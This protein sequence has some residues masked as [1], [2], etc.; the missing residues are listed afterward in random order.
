MQAAANADDAHEN[1]CSDEALE[2]GGYEEVDGEC[3]L[4]GCG[5]SGYDCDAG[6]HELIC[7]GTNPVQPPIPQP[8]DGDPECANNCF[9]NYNSAVS[10]CNK[11]AQ[12]H[13]A[14]DLF[15]IA[16][17]TLPGGETIHIA[18]VI[19]GVTVGPLIGSEVSE[20]YQHAENNRSFCMHRCGLK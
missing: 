6:C 10:D 15:L 12:W 8:S 2:N 20:C 5:W 1:V 18:G 13:I 16:T 4:T 9:R 19:A 3:L 11:D 7:G 17:L 14:E